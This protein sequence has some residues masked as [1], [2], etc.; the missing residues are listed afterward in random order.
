MHL[1]LSLEQIPKMAHQ[2]YTINIQVQNI[3]VIKEVKLVYKDLLGVDQQLL[4]ID[5]I[6]QH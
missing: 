3:L 6:I 4:Q 1:I 2:L 5:G